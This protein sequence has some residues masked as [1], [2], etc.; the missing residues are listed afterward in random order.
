V[1]VR[2]VR[3]GQPSSCNSMWIYGDVVTYLFTGDE[4]MAPVS[5]RF[6]RT[7]VIARRMV[8]SGCSCKPSLKARSPAEQSHSAAPG[9]IS[10]TPYMSSA[11]HDPA[12]GGRQDRGDPGASP[13]AARAGP[14]GM[15]ITA[16]VLQ[17]DGDESCSCSQC[18]LSLPPYGSA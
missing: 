13:H 5:L 16:D 3:V 11:G 15:A 7:Y 17:G 14:D 2:V 9:A 4:T 18:P 10:D 8:R 1:R 12:L 6:V